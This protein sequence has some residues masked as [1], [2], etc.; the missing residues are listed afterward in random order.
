[1][2]S[3]FSGQ[4]KV[5]FHWK[6]NRR[7]QPDDIF[8]IEYK[9]ATEDHLSFKEECYKTARMIYQ[10]T[11][12]NIKVL[13]SGGID[14]EVVARSFVDQNLPFQ[15]VIYQFDG[16]DMYD[17][18]YAVNFCKS[19]NINYS[20]VPF[21]QN[22]FADTGFW[23]ITDHLMSHKAFTA[24]DV[25]R[26]NQTEGYAVFGNGDVH[27]EH[28][29]GEFYSLEEGAYALPWLWQKDYDLN[30]CYRFFKSRPELQLSFINHPML[31]IWRKNAKP[32]GFE[33]SRW[34]KQWIFK[35]FWPDMLSRP[36]R[37]GYEIINKLYST[38][39]K[40]CQEKYG[41]ENSNSLIPEDKLLKQLQKEK[42]SFFS[43]LQ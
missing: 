36:K 9:S 32:M 5:R 6:E 11:D 4:E 10:S 38:L 27:I 15:A 14:S 12:L 18:H 41:Y 26:W 21:H 33:D 28:H 40:Q 19:K 34:W 1:M 2:N 31:K 37:T 35:D 24:F 16:Q 3:S 22:K 8:H 43:F 23:K 42:K 39:D 29:N 25:E 30:G 13:M 7:S 20:V 17:I